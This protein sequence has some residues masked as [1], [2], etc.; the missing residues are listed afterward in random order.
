MFENY[1]KSYKHPMNTNEDHVNT[2]EYHAKINESNRK[3]DA[4]LGDMHICMEICIYAYMRIHAY[5]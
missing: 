5:T 1:I 4:A 3:N 2:V